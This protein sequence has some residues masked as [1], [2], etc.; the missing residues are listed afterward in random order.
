MKANFCAKADVAHA[1]TATKSITNFFII[2][3]AF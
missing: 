2:I 1:A 3:V